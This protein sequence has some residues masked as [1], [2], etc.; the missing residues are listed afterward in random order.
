VSLQDA[1]GSVVIG[2]ETVLHAGPQG[3]AVTVVNWGGSIAIDNAITMH[4]DLTTAGFVGES[5]PSRVVDALSGS[6]LH[7]S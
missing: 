1:D 5:R 4:L 7:P 2:I 6:D 3:A